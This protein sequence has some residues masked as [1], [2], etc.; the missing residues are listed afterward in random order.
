MNLPCI[1]PHHQYYQRCISFLPRFV[2]TLD[3]IT[4]SQNILTIIKLQCEKNLRKL[5]LPRRQALYSHDSILFH[6]RVH[7][8]VERKQA[9]LPQVCTSPQY[10]SN[11]YIID[12]Q[13]SCD[14]VCTPRRTIPEISKCTDGTIS[15]LCE[16]CVCQIIYSRLQHH[17][18]APVNTFHYL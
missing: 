6:I 8:P 5:K 13:L 3:L 7:Q 15:C 16:R 14:T 11:V 1:K 4:V 17:F 12:T 9:D 10:S 2:I 18:A